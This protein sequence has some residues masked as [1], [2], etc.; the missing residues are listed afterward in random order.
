MKIYLKKFVLGQVTLFVLACFT[1]ASLVLQ[2]PTD[3]VRAV[4][5]W[6]ADNGAN[7]LLI[8]PMETIEITCGPGDDTVTIELVTENMPNNAAIAYYKVTR[9]IPDAITKTMTCDVAPGID[10]LFYGFD[11]KDTFRN[12]TSAPSVVYGGDGEDRLTGGSGTDRI[13]GEGD[14]DIID[15][16][17][18][19]DQA[20]GDDGND[21]ILGGDGNDSLIGGEGNDAIVG[22]A[23][24]DYVQADEG[25]DTCTGGIG[26]DT[27]SGDE[28]NDTLDG[29]E[30]NDKLY[31]KDGNDT[32]YGGDGDDYL[33]CGS[34]VNTAKGQE[35]KDVI[36]GGIETDL[37]FGDDGNDRLYGRGGNDALDGGSGSD[38]LYGGSGFDSLN[39]GT[40]VDRILIHSN[41][42]PVMDGIDSDSSDFTV[43][44]K[45]G[46]EIKHGTDDDY[47]DE[48]GNNK[49]VDIVYGPASWTETYIEQAD[50]TLNVVFEV[51]NQLLQRKGKSITLILQDPP[52][53]AASNGWN[54]DNGDI[55]IFNKSSHA[56]N[57]WE[58]VLV[59]EIGHNWD[60][61]NDDWGE[62]K[63]I[64]SW[65]WSPWNT[66][67]DWTRY[68][69]DDYKSLWWYK[70][71][72]ES[73][74][75]SYSRKSPYEDFAC[76]FNEYIRKGYDSMSDVPTKRDFLKKFISDL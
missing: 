15:C 46:E 45:N 66:S 36:Y 73:I 71:G 54:A 20:Y 11:G 63:A 26:D 10:F 43:Y 33:D 57:N 37:M 22:E 18:G 14:N 60:N 30:G 3:N 1:Q 72:S 6:N 69:T 27:V 16:G 49:T 39:G 52:S 32:I 50:T 51:S 35:G 2:H 44:F 61:E 53:N 58:D 17:A 68:E 24:N 76:H 47:V 29:M 59:H 8:F 21:E 9:Q 5:G 70:V 74:G 65:I 38:G 67:D 41:E 34:G 62:W 13:S 4:K 75:E 28:G 23:G 42:F 56:N 25:D 12:L 7:F 19:D 31:G 55:H 40:G 64:C 48:K